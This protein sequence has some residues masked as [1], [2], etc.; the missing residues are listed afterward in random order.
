M[1]N[2]DLNEKNWLAIFDPIFKGPVPNTWAKMPKNYRDKQQ[3]DVTILDKSLWAFDSHQIMAG[4]WPQYIAGAFPNYFEIPDHKSGKVKMGQ[5][6]GTHWYHAHKH[7]STSL[8]ILSGLAGAL[9]IEGEY[10]QFLR[11]FYGLGDTTPGVF[12]KILVIQS[13][14]P[15]QNLTRA[16]SNNAR[17][18]S[19]QQLVNGM[20]Q[21]TIQ[22][23]PNE[24]Q[25]WRIVNAT[26][27][28]F[29][30]GWV[31]PD[32]FQVPGFNSARLPWTASNSARRT[33][34]INRSSMARYPTRARRALPD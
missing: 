9:I 7:G 18:G 6:P 15:N 20:N 1:P 13:I 11:G 32:V 10:D 14:D 30:F 5:A 23:R 12:E 19:G 8:H 17:T 34:R 31:C 4:Q 22:M 33:T 2:K 27:G 21:P 16:S 29:F 25:L 24:V 28:S 3:A 26:V